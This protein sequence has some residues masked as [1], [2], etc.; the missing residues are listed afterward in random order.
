MHVSLNLW[1]SQG[2]GFLFLT[3][4]T[5]LTKSLPQFL[6]VL[7]WML[8]SPANKDMF[9]TFI[10]YLPSQ[11]VLHNNLGCLSFGPMH[12]YLFWHDTSTGRMTLLFYKQICFIL[13]W[14]NFEVW[15]D[16]GKK[17]QLWLW[18][19]SRFGFKL[20][21]RAWGPYSVMIPIIN[22][23]LRLGTDCGHSSGKIVGN[24]VFASELFL[25]PPFTKPPF[26]IDMDVTL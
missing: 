21:H 11:Q 16:L 26:Y 17:T 1:E 13:W 24:P 15:A 19:T 23:W 5:D 9:S 4:G 20:L 6:N 7:T 2:F 3:T 18:E 10:K 8:N 14:F 25:A 12:R 22:M